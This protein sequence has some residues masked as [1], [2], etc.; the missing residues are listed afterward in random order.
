MGGAERVRP[1]TVNDHL[2]VK[3]FYG[4]LAYRIDPHGQ[5]AGQYSHLTTRLGAAHTPAVRSLLHHEE[6]AAGLN[7][8]WHPDLVFKLSLQHVDGNRF[9]RPDPQDLLRAVTSGTL[10]EKTNLVP[11]G[12]QFTF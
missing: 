8:R 7:Y 1:E 11:F 2:K 5:V 4:E 9:A 10:K 12:T 6:V 3:G